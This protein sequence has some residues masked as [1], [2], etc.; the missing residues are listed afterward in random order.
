MSNTAPAA[1][2]LTTLRQRGFRLLLW[3][4]ILAVLIGLLLIIS[5]FGSATVFGVI[6]GAWM[7]VD[8]LSTTGLS[9]DLRRRGA[10]WGWMLADGVIQVLFGLLVILF[11][12]TFA[13]VSAFFVIGFLALG[14]VLSGIVQLAAPA[15]RR[16][17]WT[18]VVGVINIVFGVILGV[19]AITNPVDN[20][21]ALSWMAGISAVAL[22]IS[23][24]I[25]AVNLRTL[26]R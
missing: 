10:P 19:L 23:L 5:P 9:L 16:S 13:V 3:R 2:L 26:R 15:A 25:F 24:I 7:I 17:G 1:D 21:V 18:I 11:P 14:M 20:V 6:V 4:G 12:V 22:G 8:G